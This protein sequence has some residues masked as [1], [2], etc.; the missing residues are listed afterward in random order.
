MGYWLIKAFSRNETI[1]ANVAKGL[2][3]ISFGSMEGSWLWLT[4]PTS[5][6]AHERLGLRAG[7]TL[8]TAL[9]VG[10]SD[11]RGSAPQADFSSQEPFLAKSL[12]RA[13][14]TRKIPQL[15]LVNGRP[16][17]R[18]RP[19]RS[20][21]SADVCRRGHEGEKTATLFRSEAQRP[22]AL[23]ASFT[24]LQSTALDGMASRRSR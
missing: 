22:C 6:G 12:R 15:R 19:S 4:R 9:A 14:G 2:T 13:S 20:W 18:A 7:Q 5:P 3:I 24:I 10:E 21:R 17:G 23:Y 11:V 1:N 16:V 8:L